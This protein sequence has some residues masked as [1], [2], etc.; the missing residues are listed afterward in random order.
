MKNPTEAKAINDYIAEQN[1]KFEARC[2]AEGATCWW[3]SALTADDLAGYGVHSLA[4]YKI[5]QAENDRLCAAKEERK[6]RY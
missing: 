2:K 6:N 5:W 1:A 3:V 4:E